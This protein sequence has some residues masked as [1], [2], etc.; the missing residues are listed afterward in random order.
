MQTTTAAFEQSCSLISEK[1]TINECKEVF[2]YSNC[3]RRYSVSLHHWWHFAS[4]C[5]DSQRHG[6]AGIVN[7]SS[8]TR[9][10]RSVWESFWFLNGCLVNSLSGTYLSSSTQWSI[11]LWNIVR[12]LTI[13]VQ[14]ETATSLSQFIKKD[15]ASFAQTSSHDNKYV[16]AEPF[17]RTGWPYICQS[18]REK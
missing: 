1:C 9:C 6:C 3:Y 4:N 5:G 15:T 16:L 13:H 10:Q 2:W 18:N 17:K 14:R 11:S 8:M 12:W 7:Q